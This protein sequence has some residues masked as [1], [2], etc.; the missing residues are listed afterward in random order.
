MGK[1][2]LVDADIKQGREIVALLKD[3]GFPIHSARWQFYDESD[4]WRL[5]IVTPLVS[6]QG[7]LAAYGRLQAIL[8]EGNGH[9]GISLFD[10][11]L[12]APNDPLVQRQGMPTAVGVPDRTR[13]DVTEAGDVRLPGIYL[14]AAE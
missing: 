1:P 3:K 10:F 5:V 7:G 6:Q 8:T 4:E 12:V 11:T 14:Y 2:F 9:R 13:I